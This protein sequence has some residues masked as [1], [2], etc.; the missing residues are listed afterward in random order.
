M[1]T[2]TRSRI[3]VNIK[4]ESQSRGNIE[5]GDVRKWIKKGTKEP[6]EGIEGRKGLSLFAELK[7]GCVSRCGAH[8]LKV[9]RSLKERNDS[10][11]VISEAG[12]W[13]KRFLRVFLRGAYRLRGTLRLRIR[14]GADGADGTCSK[15]IENGIFGILSANVVDVVQHSFS[16][17]SHSTSA[18]KLQHR[19][20]GE[21][22]VAMHI[23]RCGEVRL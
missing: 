12:R 1:H 14:N 2:Q 7:L 13:W 5:C 18:C 20:F 19:I 21:S 16:P 8:P 9:I 17:V 4:I 6:K 23:E 10:R 22:N 3:S 15:E 11:P